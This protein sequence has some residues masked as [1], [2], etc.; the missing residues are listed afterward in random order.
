[1]TDLPPDTIPADAAP[2]AAPTHSAPAAWLPRMDATY[3]P[4]DNKLRLYSVSRLDAD[5]Y[6]RVKDA[7][8]KW[9]PKQELFVAP[10]WTPE[11]AALLVELC[12]EIGDEDT[13]LVERAEARADRFE[14]YSAK[15]ADDARAA[16]DAVSRIAD[17]IPL[18]QPILV[19][20]HSEKRARK[21]AER[22][23]SGMRRAVQMWETSEYWTARAKGALSHAKY[24][25]LPAVRHRRIKGLESDKRKQLKE[26]ESSERYTRLW[27]KADLTDDQAKAI[28]NYDHALAFDTWGKLDRGE[29][30]AP[31]A[32]AHALEVHARKIERARAWLAHIEGRLAY[33]R[34]MLGEPVADKFPIEIGG[35]VTSTHWRARGK[36]W[37]VVTKIN[38]DATGAIGSVSTTEGVIEI[39]SVTGYQAPEAGTVAAVKASKKLPPLVNYPGEGFV[40]MTQAEY[41]ARAKC[42]DFY[43]VR[44]MPAT[45][46]HGAHRLRH[47]PEG[48]GKYGLRGVYLTDA[49]RVDPPSSAATAATP[50]NDLAPTPAATVTRATVT[51]APRAPRARTEFD[52]MKDALRTGVAVV[53]V[54]APELFPTPPALACRMV[55]L[56]GV[57]PGMRV[58]EPS[59]GTGNIV[60][61]IVKAGA[62]VLA[63]EIEGK[64]AGALRAQYPDHEVCALDFA[65]LD[66]LGGIRR[67][68]AAVMNPPFSQE[69]AHVG[70]AFD[71]LREGGVLVSV[72]SAGVKFRQNHA[73]AEFRAFVEAHGGTIEDLPDDTFKASG[74]SVRTVLVTVRK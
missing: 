47:A 57:R 58:L 54:S 20:H 40:H 44:K 7:G 49:K 73:H 46:A 11:R 56:A 27:G 36:G 60:R 28:A 22:I 10:M 53:A 9:A 24:K 74:T 66:D 13:S 68:D 38:R 14:D 48:A 51:R 33:E 41:T 25:E 19:G 71:L 59:A 4:E 69:L 17:G 43:H 23:Q 34:A 45:D 5:T 32:S 30:H 31:E 35:R 70:R 37:I 8:F 61:E 50:G 52:D 63:V 15:R 65:D 55:E 2:D 67:F 16:R 42:S 39:E 21:D 72:M 64:L 18:G 1:M 62:D 3:S 12:G 6:K 26:I 29:L